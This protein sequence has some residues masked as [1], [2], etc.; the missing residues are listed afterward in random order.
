MP[1]G[2]GAPGLVLVAD[3]HTDSDAERVRAVNDV[4]PCAVAAA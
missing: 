1:G 4:R 2:G 3:A